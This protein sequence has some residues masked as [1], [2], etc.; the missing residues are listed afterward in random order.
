MAYPIEF[1]QREPDLYHAGT[2][3]L[4]DV[5]GRQDEGFNNLVLVGHNPGLT[6]LTNLLVP[7]LT[8]NVP[9]AGFVSVLVDTDTWELRGSKS[10]DLLEYNYPKKKR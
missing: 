4:F 1:L 7:G 10:V 3:L 5:I 9:T 6:E 2:A 8:S